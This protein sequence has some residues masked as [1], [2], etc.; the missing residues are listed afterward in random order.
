[1][2][3]PL[4]ALAVRP[5]RGNNRET[6]LLGFEPPRTTLLA[7]IP[8]APPATMARAIRRLIAPDALVVVP[9]TRSRPAFAE[10]LH[11]AR[12][13]ACVPAD[14]LRFLW[15][16]RDE[17]DLLAL[18][19]ASDRRLLD[20]RFLAREYPGL[21]TDAGRQAV[22]R[23]LRETA[24]MIGVRFPLPDAGRQGPAA[25]TAFLEAGLG[26]IAT[27]LLLFAAPIAEVVEGD[28]VL[29][30]SDPWLREH[31]ARR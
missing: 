10:A 7:F 13:L 22:A 9:S 17:H 19:H 24:L 20:D 8:E 15:F 21:R 16:Y 6:L 5:A 2:A 31:A 4:T 23:L 27:L 3:R 26:L 25:T 28:R 18:G 1:V 29:R 14:V 30:L 11:P 12:V